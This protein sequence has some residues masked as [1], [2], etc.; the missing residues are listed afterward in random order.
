MFWFF[1]CCRWVLWQGWLTGIFFFKNKE[2][3]HIQY[4]YFEN[5]RIC[6]K[7]HWILYEITDFWD[8]MPCSLVH[9]SHIPSTLM[10]LSKRNYFYLFFYLEDAGT[11]FL[12]NVGTYPPNCT[13]SHSRSLRSYTILKFSNL[14]IQGWVKWIPWKCKKI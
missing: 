7:V 8:L 11:R 3:T 13:T 9:V 5:T 14:M 10:F 6:D 4:K 1:C 2:Q 12:L